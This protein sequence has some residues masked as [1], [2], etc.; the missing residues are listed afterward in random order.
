[1][2][3]NIV[4]F[5]TV[6]A[7]AALSGVTA[8]A[9]TNM[10]ADIPFAF[11]VPLVDHMPSGE[12]RIARSSAGGNITG[13]AFQHVA[14]RKTVL[15]MAPITFQR[16]VNWK[17]YPAQLVFQCR[18]KACALAGVYPAGSQTGYAVR[19]KLPAAPPNTQISEIR[20]PLATAD[21]Y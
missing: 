20:V 2:T 8:S 1:M 18:G 14:S 6:A 21:G 19:V 17:E 10:K 12:Y 9:Q 13:Y 5:A 7:L 3:Q 15:T 16:P 11:S 4:R